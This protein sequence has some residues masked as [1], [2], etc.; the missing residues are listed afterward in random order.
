MDYNVDF[1]DVKFQI[2][3]WL[4]TQ[5]LLGHGLYADWD[6]E[7]LE[8]VLAEALKISQEEIAPTNED[9]DQEGCVL[10][11]GVVRVPESFISNP[12]PIASMN[13]LI[14]NIVI[15]YPR[16]ATPSTLPTISAAR[17]GSTAENSPSRSPAILLRML[18]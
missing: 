13:G 10:E 2:F 17:S 8:M 5:R 3:D 4:P 9:G 1:R 16:K 18:K 14:T 6:R 11:E 15:P 12:I 7:S